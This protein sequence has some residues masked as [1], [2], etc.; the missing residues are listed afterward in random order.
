MILSGKEI[1][2]HMGN[3]IIIK[4]FNKSQL[5]PNS[6][7]LRLADELMIYDLHELDMKKKNSGHLIKIPEEGYLLEPNKLYLARTMEYT[8][9]ECFVPMLE[10]RSSVGRLG[11]FIHVTAGFGDVGFSGY[12]TLEMF[13]VQPIRIYSG[14]EICQIYFHTV[15]GTADKYDSGKYQNNKGIQTS[16]LYKDFEA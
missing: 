16:L 13:C 12:W 11:L 6:Y 3:E 7:N 10:G 15:L 8:K 5:N 14:V 1:E 2:R 4:P 9:T